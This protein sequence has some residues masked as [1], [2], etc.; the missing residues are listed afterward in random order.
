MRIP[1]I[2]GGEFSTQKNFLGNY[3]QCKIDVYNMLCHQMNQFEEKQPT[4]EFRMLNKCKGI[5][6]H[7]LL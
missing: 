1:P 6:L 4:K 5:L 3:N 7:H 2:T